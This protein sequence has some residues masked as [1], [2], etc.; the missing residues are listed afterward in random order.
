MPP[1]MQQKKSMQNVSF[2]SVSELLDF[3]PKGQLAIAE[4][5]R[6]LVLETIPGVEEKLSYCVP[7]YRKRKIICYFWPGA[8]SWGGKTSE[9]VEFGFQYG[10][11]LTDE[12][13]YLD[14]GKRK[15]VFTKRFFSVEDIDE[16][17]LR[18]YLLEA[19]ELDELMYR[20][21]RKR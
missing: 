7:F 12:M 15:Q 14:R 21:K 17:I 4:R 20:E 2:R 11:L 9:G 16:D 19:A 18:S 1:S 13:N 5:L 10:N 3:L 8:V 6:E